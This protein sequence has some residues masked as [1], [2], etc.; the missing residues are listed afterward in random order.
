MTSANE[1]TNIVTLENIK[2]KF[3]QLCW[4]IE[5]TDTTKQLNLLKEVCSE[6]QFKD[7]KE[8]AKQTVD[9]KELC[10]QQLRKNREKENE[11]KRREIIELKK[12]LVQLERE[13]RSREKEE[14]KE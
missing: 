3:E 6:F 8:Q 7:E 12:R 14:S 9:T 4:L 1:F 2:I 13:Q 11:W 5:H 10:R